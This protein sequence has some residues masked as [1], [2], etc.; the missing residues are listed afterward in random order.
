V[1][2]SEADVEG[3]MLTDEATELDIVK[4][5]GGRQVDGEARP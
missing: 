4:M 1:P 2:E 3:F 5:A